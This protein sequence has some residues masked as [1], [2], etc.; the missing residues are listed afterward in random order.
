MCTINGMTF[1]AP[2]CMFFSF[3]YISAV[4]TY[5]HCDTCVLRTVDTWRIQ[6]QVPSVQLTA[7]YVWVKNE[8]NSYDRDKGQR[9]HVHAF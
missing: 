9:F 5:S 6:L 3:L 8:R 7:T 1:H 2:P 4:F